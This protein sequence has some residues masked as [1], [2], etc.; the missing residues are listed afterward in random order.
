MVKNVPTQKIDIRFLVT[1]IIKIIIMVPKTI[2]GEC[3]ILNSE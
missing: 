1:K 3:K 2:E